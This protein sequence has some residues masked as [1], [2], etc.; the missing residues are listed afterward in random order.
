MRKV[1]I[2]GIGAGNPDY[3]TVQAI[4]ALNEVDVFFVMDKDLRQRIWSAFARKSASATSRTSRTGP[5]RSVIQSAI[6]L[7][8]RMSRALKHGTSREP[9][10]MRD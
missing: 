2:I 1:F 5:S 3:I 7:R 9:L 6:E 8:R 4:N 10:Y